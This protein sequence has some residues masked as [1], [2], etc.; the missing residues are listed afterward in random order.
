MK[1]LLVGLLVW[2]GYLFAAPL[3][4]FVCAVINIGVVISSGGD[5][6]F[7]CGFEKSKDE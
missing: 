3:A 6:K 2:V 5:Y 7:A 1:K 4:A